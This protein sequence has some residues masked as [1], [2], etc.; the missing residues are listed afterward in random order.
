MKM[1]GDRG[2]HP[3]IMT[4][5]GLEFSGTG[6]FGEAGVG[7]GWVRPRKWVREETE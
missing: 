1:R 2:K 4:R 5:V 7:E 3:E 6:L